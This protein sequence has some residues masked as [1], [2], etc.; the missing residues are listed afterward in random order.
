MAGRLSGLGQERARARGFRMTLQR[1]VILDAIEALEGG[2][3]CRADWGHCARTGVA[4]ACEASTWPSDW[5]RRS[6]S[7]RAS[8]L[9]PCVA[10]SHRPMPTP[11]SSP[12]Q[13]EPPGVGWA[14]AAGE[15]ASG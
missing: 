13:P 3:G 11:T 12:F 5:T 15:A 14:V 10:P 2:D 4:G 7:G 6:R 8:R 9:T 1:Q